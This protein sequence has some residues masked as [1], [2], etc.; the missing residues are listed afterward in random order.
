MQ[1]VQEHKGKTVFVVF[2]ENGSFRTSVHGKI[3]EADSHGI[4]VE[5]MPG[6]YAMINSKNIVFILDSGGYKIF[7]QEDLELKAKTK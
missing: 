3:L 4:M 1:K 6:A 7:D 2:K 5:R